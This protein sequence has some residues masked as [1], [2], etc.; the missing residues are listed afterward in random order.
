[1]LSPSL[2]LRSVF[3]DALQKVFSNEFPVSAEAPQVIAEVHSDLVAAEAVL[4]DAM[5][6]GVVDEFLLDVSS[7]VTVLAFGAVSSPDVCRRFR[8][9]SLA[10]AAF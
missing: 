2:W 4:K 3:S 9:Q 6:T 8:R 7:F 10:G 1:M 5:P